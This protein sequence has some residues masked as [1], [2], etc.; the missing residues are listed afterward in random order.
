MPKNRDAVLSWKDPGGQIADS[1][2]MR[3]DS[4]DYDG[5]EAIAYMEK[6]K[7]ELARLA[8]EVEQRLPVDRQR[9]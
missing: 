3:N 5:R 7:A 8:D 1:L 9:R 2:K 6:Y 4:E